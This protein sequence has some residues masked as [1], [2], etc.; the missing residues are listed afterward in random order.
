MEGAWLNINYVDCYA[1]ISVTDPN[2]LQL[3]IKRVGL[4][5]TTTNKNKISLAV[6]CMGYM[7][8]YGLICDAKNNIIFR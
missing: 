6:P 1:S 2:L 7:L 3:Y 8:K 4:K 5:V